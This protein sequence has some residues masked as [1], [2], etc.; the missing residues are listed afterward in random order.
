MGYDIDEAAPTTSDSEDTIALEI[1]PQRERSNRGIESG[2]VSAARQNGDRPRST[3][4]S[5]SS[6]IRAP[7][8]QTHRRMRGKARREYRLRSVTNP[9]VLGKSDRE[10]M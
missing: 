4:E 7:I 8:A 1:R 10:A 5:P 2:H 3:H 9:L 6:V